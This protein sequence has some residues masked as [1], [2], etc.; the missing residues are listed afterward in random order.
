MRGP[1]WSLRS[2][3]A[4]LSG[5]PVLRTICPGLLSA[6]SVALLRETRKT[7]RGT[8]VATTSVIAC[9]AISFVGVKSGEV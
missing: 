8:Q 2:V 3:G 1:R 7:D 5:C 9:A 6:A 4:A